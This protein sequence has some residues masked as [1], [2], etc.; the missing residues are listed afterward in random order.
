MERE[1]LVTFVFST[2]VVTTTVITGLDDEE[3]IAE[4]A[5]REIME[6]TGLDL[7]SASWEVEEA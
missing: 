4:T 5:I 2:V 1:Y 6:E 3:M 7:N